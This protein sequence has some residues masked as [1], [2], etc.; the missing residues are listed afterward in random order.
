VTKNASAFG[1]LLDNAGPGARERGQGLAQRGVVSLESVSDTVVHARVQGTK[2]Y[3]VTL[4][5]S[6][7][8]SW[9]CDCPAAA[10][11]SFCKHCVAVVLVLD[12]PGPAAG[13]T[14]ELHEGQLT[15]AG[16]I[17]AHVRS[18]GAKAL[19]EIVLDQVSIDEHLGYRLLAAATAQAGDTIDLREW[20]KR[21]TAAFRGPG[22]FIDWR[23]ASEWARGV[24]DMLDV[25][26]AFLGAG[27]ASEVAA[28]AEHAHR[29]AES[30]VNRVDDSGGEIIGIIGV[31]REIHL[32]AAEAGAYPPKK[33]GKRLADLEL[34]A[35]LD[36]FHRSAID[37][38]EVLGDDGLGAYLAVVDKAQAKRA[39]GADRW[40]PAFRIRQALIAHAIAAADPDRLI[41][42]HAGED[43]MGS[44]DY[45]E[46][47]ELLI[48]ACRFDEAEDWADRGLSVR[49]GDRSLGALRGLRATLM[50][51][52]AGGGAE[53]EELY[54]IEF[55]RRPGAPTVQDLFANCEDQAV[56]RGRVFEKLD[57]A[58]EAVRA[59][60]VA[61]EVDDPL[62]R[63]GTSTALPGSIGAPTRYLQHRGGPS[64]GSAAII[65]VLVVLG[66]AERAWSVALEFGAES[67]LWSDLVA[68][69]VDDHPT[70]AVDWAMVAAEMEIGRKGRSHY[71]RAVRG[72]RVAQAL[73]ENHD[74]AEH[75]PLSQR[76][77]AG[78]RL[79][80]EKHS[81]KPSMLEE[82]AKAGWPRAAQ[83]DSPR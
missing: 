80:V 1:P 68:R 17:E 27:H 12:T 21:V 9:A 8:G 3:R 24:H 71:R 61:D 37:Y 2:R 46:L 6:E 59:A 29:R 39:P 65:D 40:G 83:D 73:A 51:R 38:G 58:V 18:L 16:R 63:A 75:G 74:D 10:D 43:Q 32:A 81:N 33:L 15:E 36:T 23:N 41:E 14:S 7:T 47:V 13:A 30:A 54:W 22:G 45:V 19:A 56:T 69:R 79:I 77:H 34:S 82:F 11:G 31:V 76:F 66:D 48:A 67:R 26:Q 57:A 62:S 42:V 64:F 72:L 28:L 78:L 20:K 52:G 70:D 5:S 53:V 44:S 49:S 55:V 50:R 60:L 35:S 25:L 4:R